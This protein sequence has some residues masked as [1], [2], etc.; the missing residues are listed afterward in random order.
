M[1]TFNDRNEQGTKH[2]RG[3]STDQD[4][5]DEQAFKLSNEWLRNGDES[6]QM[7]TRKVKMWSE[8]HQK[9]LPQ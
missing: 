2:F 4:L 6:Y 7:D 9:W 3:L 8:D 5:T 1:W